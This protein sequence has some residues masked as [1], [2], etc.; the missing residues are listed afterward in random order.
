MGPA[1]PNWHDQPMPLTLRRA[2]SAL[3]TRITVAPVSI[4]WVEQHQRDSV[5]H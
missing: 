3:L 1:Q 4:Q 2:L 5:K